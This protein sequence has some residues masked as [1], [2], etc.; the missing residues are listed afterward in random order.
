MLPSNTGRTYFLDPIA[1]M[2]NTH[3]TTSTKIAKVQML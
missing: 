3:N 1:R 2:C